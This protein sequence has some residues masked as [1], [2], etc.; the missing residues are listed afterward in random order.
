MSTLIVVDEPG[1]WPLEIPGGEVV[2][3]RAY[4]TEPRY[5]S[6][7]RARVYNLCESYRYQSTGYYVSLLG[8]A[9]GHGTLPDVLTMQDIKSRALIRHADEL[10]ELIRRS[11]RDISTSPFELSI[12]FGRNLAERHA[13]LS[14]ALFNLFPVPLLRASFMRRRDQWR[15]DRLKPIPL[16]EIPH[17]HRGFLRDAIVEHFSRR[18]P[19]RQVPAA[20][21]ELAILAN[22]DEESPP[23]DEAALRRFVRAAQ[24]VGFDVDIL[25]PDDFGRIAEF[26]ALFIRET[27]RVNHH[28]Y[29]FAS[30][31]RALGLVVIDD[32][33]SI[34]RCTNKVYLAELMA[35]LGIPTPRT[36]I[37]HRENVSQVGPALGFP[38]VLKVPDSAFS[39]G[40]IKVDDE[41]TLRPRLRELLE[42]SDLVVAQEFVPTDFDWRVGI[43]DRT[44]LYVCRY[45]MA[46]S[47]WQI[48]KQHDGGRVS[49]GR[50]D[51]LPLAEAPPGVIELAL[52]AANAIGDGLYGVDIKSLAD[53]DV[54]IEVNDNPSIERGVEDRIAGDALYT[55]IMQVFRQRLEAGKSGAHGR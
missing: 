20:R 23:S 51:S 26:D 24:A 29:R 10:D 8:A 49:G 47:H 44:P 33:D 53:R 7:R 31:A 52:R 18:M 22:P 6:L 5:S 39:Q 16:G 41:E 13:R 43:I 12:Y 30:R 54:V 14:R 27:T 19:A 35:R 17:T 15:L 40:V 21:F 50:W 36:L 2:G 1:E 55:R 38:V 34:A 37:V 42:D 46:R 4:L 25:G 32:P 11:L 45:F 48:Y 28:T 9:R 3:A